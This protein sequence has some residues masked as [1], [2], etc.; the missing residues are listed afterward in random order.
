MPEQ[1][2]HSREH[3]AVWRLGCLF[4][5]LYFVQ[6]LAEPAEGLIAQPVRSLLTSWQQTPGQIAQF[7]AV[8]GLPWAI[9][10][11]YGLLV[12]CVP[13]LG[14]RRRSY[15]VLASA[16]TAG[17]L[18]WLAAAVPGFGQ[19]QRL[20]T[21]LLIPTVAV[22]VADV[23]A[24][25]LLVEQGRPLGLTGRLQSIQWAAMY[26]ASVLAGWLGGRLS[27]VKRQDLS[28]LICGIGAALTCAVAVLWVRDQPADDTGAGQA[29]GSSPHHDSSGDWRTRVRLLGQTLVSPTFLQISAFLWLWNFNPFSS[30]IQHLYLTTYCGLDE[31]HY[32]QTVSLFSLACV[33]A[34]LLYAAMCRRLPVTWLLPVCILSGVLSTVVY[35]VVDDYQSACVASVVSGLAYMLGNLIQLDLAARLCPAAVA[36]TFF[37]LLMSISNLAIIVSTSVGGVLYETWSAGRTPAEAWSRL[38]LL[39]AATTALCCGLLPWFRQRT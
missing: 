28:F 38:V 6:G 30:T 12:D 39:G 36:A 33:A 15:L 11:L 22:A 34:C 3:R 8:V 1:P 20:L 17:S 14:S 2:D 10:P 25:A 26:C 37:A 5:V 29:P 7:M 35:L 13:L 4:A 32:G 9:K 31:E 21:L 27:A 24:D 16:A 18:F 19:T 23:V